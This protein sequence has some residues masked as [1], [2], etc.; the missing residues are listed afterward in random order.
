MKT[1]LASLL[2]FGLLL[3]PVLGQEKPDLTNQREQ[4]SYAMGMSIAT[5]LKQQG[6]DIDMKALVAGLTDAQAGTPALTPEEQKATM[7]AMQSDI[8]ARREAKRKIDAVKNL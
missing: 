7:K 3:N 2:A 5:K 8:K 1:C 4:I 6:V